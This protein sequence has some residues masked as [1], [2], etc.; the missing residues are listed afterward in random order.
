MTQE[1]VEWRGVEER[2]AVTKSC[3]FESV[4]AQ[5]QQQG[6]TNGRIVVDDNDRGI[7]QNERQHFSH[8]PA[9]W[10]VTLIIQLLRVYADSVFQDFVRQRT[11]R[12]S[13]ASGGGPG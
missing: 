6:I 7:P 9:P 11:G 2:F 10:C 3:G 13:D 5:Q 12:T 4:D 8:R 1:G